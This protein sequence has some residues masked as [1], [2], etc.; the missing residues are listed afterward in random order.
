MAAGGYAALLSGGMQ[1]GSGYH[2]PFSS[3]SNAQALM[4]LL[5]TAANAAAA[6]AVLKPELWSWKKGTSDICTRCL[7]LR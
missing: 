2:S 6:V 1:L 3:S 4:L 5:K 7:Q